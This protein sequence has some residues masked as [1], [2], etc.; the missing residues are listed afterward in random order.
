MDLIPD[1]QGLSPGLPIIDQDQFDLKR[2][3]RI[4]PHISPGEGHFIARLKKANNNSDPVNRNDKFFK[5]G[6]YRDPTGNYKSG[7]GQQGGHSRFKFG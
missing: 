2:S 6:H 4:W 5:S 3:A 1:I 7:T